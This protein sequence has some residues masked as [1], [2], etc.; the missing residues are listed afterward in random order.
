M[1]GFYSVVKLLDKHLRFVFITGVSKFAKVSVFSGMNNLTDISMDRRYAT[2]CGITQQELETYFD[3]AIDELAVLEQQERGELQTKIKHWYNGYHFH[4]KAIGVYNP[5]SILSLFSKQEFK[6]YWFTT[7]TPTFLLDLLQNKQYDLKNLTEFE[8]GDG[9]FEACEP[10]EIGVQS[11]FL[12][13]GYLTIKEYNAP[14]YKLD[15]PNYEVK[16]SFYDSVTTRYSKLDKGVGESYTNQLLHHLK[17]QN[18]DDFFETLR[19][20]FANVPYDI[21]LNH[22]KYYQSL[23]YAIFKLLGL[24]VEVEVSTNIG[25]IDCVIQTDN[26][27]YIIEFKLN[28]SKEKA[29]KQIVDKQYAQ[30]YQDCGKAVLLVGVEF[31]QA[32]RNI[33]EF[34]C[35]T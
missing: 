22:E 6:N 25:R 9:A 14:L 34:V 28:E 21:A 24:W 10:E 11:I 26:T 20:F 2:I 29:L 3:E 23:F 33:G 16:K 5:Y 19:V 32:T 27:V 30:K 31:D 4:Q 1:S 7:A 13:T 12:Q 15:F 18:L 35:Q 8:V 17:T